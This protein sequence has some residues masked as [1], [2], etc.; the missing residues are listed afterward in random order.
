MES[1]SFIFERAL[2]GGLMKL[3][4]NESQIACFVIDTLKP[5][6]FYHMTYRSV[7]K[8]IYGLNKSN[9]YFDLLSVISA[10]KENEQVSALDIDQAY[11]FRADPSLMREY[12][13]EIVNFSIE[14]FAIGKIADLS[15][16]I[17]NKDNGTIQQRIGLAESVLNSL[18]EQMQAREERGLKDGRALANEW[19]DE[20]EAYQKG[21]DHV[22][23]FG[24]DG[25]DEIIKPKSIKPGSLIVVGARPKMG[26]TFFLTK[27]AEHYV[28]N[29]D[30]A[31]CLFSM[32]MRGSDIWERILSGYAKVNSDR[33]YTED[34]NNNSFWDLVGHN[35]TELA[36]KKIYVDDRGGNNM[37]QIKAEVR[38]VHR[39]N[40]VGMIGIDY[41]TLMD[42]EEAERN[43]LKYG[44]ITKELKILA[45]E[46]N[47]IVVLLTQLNRN[48]ESRQDKRPM[49]S[50]SRDTGQIEQDCDVWIGLYRESVY[51]ENCG[52]Q[53]TEAI[54]R[55]N[56]TG[57]TGT[58]FMELKNGYFE[59]IDCV[60]A[61]SKLEDIAK[62]KKDNA[63]EQEYRSKY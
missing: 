16:V 9:R 22:Y 17:S 61:N 34:A 8:V 55:L 39:E 2:I 36:N 51:D 53:M 44:K 59:D 7:F 25:I 31:A 29:R 18:I 10:M 46:L 3:G 30:Q 52:H 60:T 12:T 56:R 11:E 49:P 14:R 50:D 37:N 4:S 26:K 21:D 28:V 5:A 13:K 41:L 27:M 40:K 1:N 47:C 45:K 33:F 6:N 48:L 63:G 38:R 62:T 15:D 42:G 35:N 23:D 58:A 19:I 20:I 57:S 54:I 24:I 32:E 43:D